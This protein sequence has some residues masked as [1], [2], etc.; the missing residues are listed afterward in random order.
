MKVVSKLLLADLKV[1]VAPCGNEEVLVKISAT[2]ER[3]RKEAHRIHFRKRV[4][5]TDRSGK[6]EDNDIFRPF[7]RSKVEAFEV[8]KNG[9]LFSSSERQRLIES[10]MRSP[11]GLG[12][13]GIDPQA[14]IPIDT[15]AGSARES[16]EASVI[17]DSFVTHHQLVVGRLMRSWGSFNPLRPRSA[18]EL[19]GYMGPSFGF[20]FAWLAFY[21]RWLVLPALVGIGVFVAQVKASSPSK[22]LATAFWAVFLVLW[23]TFFTQHWPR[24]EKKLAHKWGVLDAEEEEPVRP[25]FRPD[26]S[27]MVNGIKF[28]Y[29]EEEARSLK[30]VLSGLV[31]MLCTAAAVAVYT[32]YLHASAQTV[33]KWG[34]AGMIG[35]S[36]VNTL[37][38]LIF[39]FLYRAVATRLTE[40]EN[41][42]TQTEFDD[43]LMTKLFV[44]EFINNYFML[45]YIGFFKPGILFAGSQCA[46]DDCMAELQ[47]HMATLFTTKTTVMQVVEVFTP[48]FKT[49][50]LDKFS[51]S[52][53]KFKERAARYR[54][55]HGATD[56]DSDGGDDDTT[57]NG[58]PLRSGASHGSDDDDDE[59]HGHGH[60]GGRGGRG[61]GASEDAPPALSEPSD[62]DLDLVM[63]RCKPAV[64][65]T[66]DEFNEMVLQFGFIVLF[67]ASF[68]LACAV[69]CLNNFIEIRGDMFK[70]CNFTRRPFWRSAEDIGRWSS[71]LNTLVLVGIVST[72]SMVCFTSG[73]VSDSLLANGKNTPLLRW[74]SADLW[75]VFVAIEHLL[76]LV[77]FSI[78]ALVPDVPQALRVQAMLRSRLDDEWLSTPGEHLDNKTIHSR[79]EGKAPDARRALGLRA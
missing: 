56:R 70:L 30:Y 32:L 5:N 41:H 37:T 58:K 54:A 1:S 42:R 24:S 69:A 9:S 55:E 17:M 49:L 38:V 78:G 27:V 33:E 8:D 76:I 64:D 22:T 48:W 63:Q 75:T 14:R 50:A 59:G 52:T 77:Y 25:Q 2:E 6:E 29:Y 47:V 65:G 79:V 31:V 18:A 34:T 43:A 28:E 19:Q 11:I 67:G 73:L 3:L 13:A 35:M 45:F 62:L 44:F 23:A 16:P 10:I 39:T 72:T 46:G 53:A 4:A 60:G 40:N 12:G 20:Y 57:R 26:K 15:E 7:D 61:G 21:T 51:K 36:V 68:P 66:F 74:G 71:L